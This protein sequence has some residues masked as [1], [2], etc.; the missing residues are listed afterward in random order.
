LESSYCDEKLCKLATTNLWWTKIW[1]KGT[2][3]T[4]FTNEW[5]SLNLRLILLWKPFWIENIY[6]TLA[7]PNSIVLNCCCS[8]DD[9]ETKGKT[10]GVHSLLMLCNT[11]CCRIFSNKSDVLLCCA[12]DYH[13]VTPTYRIDH[14][15]I[16]FITVPIWQWSLRTKS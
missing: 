12:E 15:S 11:I 5:M 13:Q 14:P 16:V 7:F 2:N 8:W 3:C 4:K 10:E 6:S 1:I 9:K